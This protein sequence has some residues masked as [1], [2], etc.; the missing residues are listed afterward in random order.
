MM[1][2][3]SV[4][5]RLNSL[6]FRKGTVT[7]SYTGYDIIDFS[8]SNKCMDMYSVFVNSDGL[9]EYVEFTKIKWSAKEK[10]NMP[11]VTKLYSLSQ[12]PVAR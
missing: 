8:K 7:K 1:N 3:N 9:V 12:F 5:E 10:R 11:E 2:L 6:G 4:T